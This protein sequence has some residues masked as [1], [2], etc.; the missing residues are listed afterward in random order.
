MLK[1]DSVGLK[2]GHE[3]GRDFE[4]ASEAFG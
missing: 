4:R 1:A 3:R 2:W